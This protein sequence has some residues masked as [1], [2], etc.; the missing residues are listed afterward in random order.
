[1]L[2]RFL[3]SRASSKISNAVGYCGSVVQKNPLCGRICGRAVRKF[4]NAA[5]FAAVES[6]E[7]RMK[8][9]NTL[10]GSGAKL[11]DQGADP[12]R[13]TGVATPPFGKWENIHYL[14]Y[15]CYV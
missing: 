11:P 14:G 3:L 12:R 10:A 13:V 15:E 5:G 4:S 8:T 2:K 9:M 7:C 1:M 6:L